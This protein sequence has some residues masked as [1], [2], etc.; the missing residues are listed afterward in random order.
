[1]FS[2]NNVDETRKRAANFAHAICN[3]FEEA[4]N[5]MLNAV[6]A[7]TSLVNFITAMQKWRTNRGTDCWKRAL[8]TVENFEAS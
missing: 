1:M 6:Q 3:E 4:A 7:S 2:C 8:P 5:S